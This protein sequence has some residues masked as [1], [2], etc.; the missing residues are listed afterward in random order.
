[1]FAIRARR[2]L[3]TEKDFLEAVNK[4][5]KGY[6]KFSATP[7]QRSNSVA[8]RF[9]AFWNF[10]AQHS[11]SLFQIGATELGRELLSQEGELDIFSGINNRK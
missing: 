9:V 5:V 8:Q 7:P 1:M 11:N 2:K 3:A 10:V 4:V 6:A